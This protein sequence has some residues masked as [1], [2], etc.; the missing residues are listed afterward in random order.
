MSETT[1]RKWIVS[2]WVSSCVGATLL[3]MH[4]PMLL[5]G[6]KLMQSDPCD[7]RCCN[8]ILEHSYLWLNGAPFHNHF[9][10]SPFYYPHPNV[11]AYTC[12]L[13]GLGPLYWPWRMAGLAPDTAFQLWTL[14][15]AVANVLA[16]YFF[17]RGIFR[18]GSFPAGFAAVFFASA[19]TLGS[20][21]ALGHQQ[22][23]CQ[24]YVIGMF[25]TAMDMFRPPEPGNRRNPKLKKWLNPALFVACLVLQLYTEFY[26]AFFAL[27]ALGVALACS[28][29]WR[30]RRLWV[31]DV[32]R[33]HV[34]PLALSGGL[35][36]LVMIP[37]LTHYLAAMHEVGG[38][39]WDEV[40]SMIPRLQS[41]INMGPL[42]WVYGWTAKRMAV[43]DLPM[44]S[45]H[46]LGLGLV[47]TLAC[48]TGLWLQ[49]RSSVVRTMVVTTVLLFLLVTQF[50]PF[51]PVAWKLVY[52]IVPGA[53]AIRG[54][55]RIGML[56]AVPA[57]VGLG[58]LLEH[59]LGR[60]RAVFYG[61][62]AVIG[63]ACLAEQFAWKRS[64]DKARMREEVARIAGE[65]RPDCEAFFYTEKRREVIWWRPNVDAM[66]AS[67]V[68]GKPT[69]NGCS[70][71]A[72]PQWK[73]IYPVTY[74]A[75]CQRKNDQYLRQWLEKNHL[76][77]RRIQ[78]I[79]Q[80]DTPAPVVLFPDQEMKVNDTPGVN[81]LGDGW[82]IPELQ[83][84]WSD[85][86]ESDLTFEISPAT[87]VEGPYRLVLKF[88]TYAPRPK[89]FR[90]SLLLN[91][92]NVCDYRTPG[93]QIQTISVEVQA[94]Q[95][96]PHNLL[97]FQ[98]SSPHSPR[99]VGQS[100]DDR[101]LCIHLC[102]VKLESIGHRR[103]TTTQAVRE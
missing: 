18:I 62:A 12:L 23:Y 75:Y 95:L 94:A 15:V 5:S 72:P 86:T 37:W 64:Y 31:V 77:A 47:T 33:A 22:L 78:W 96:K 17:L 35:A 84:V 40:K 61:L 82:S 41:W 76:D 66:W 63:M 65:V 73:L 26:G 85:G 98:F 7:S 20:H 52:W 74:H 91:G 13:A 101:L 60:K 2:V 14:T 100:A 43:N 25:A 3:L 68:A 11:T 34:L 21:L 45:E 30:E 81:M 59:L 67:L 9:W 46:W 50:A 97:R 6:L 71:N 32:L 55:T 92:E 83:G 89:E 19:N 28:L 90:F 38:R 53:G 44:M 48:G 42:S 93:D 80:V 102:S 24:A 87:L 99:D 16:M 56:L 27:L 29:V 88:Y 54:V 70:A 51:L 10:D 1:K 57:A 69:V 103:L 8:Y 4:Y 58:F 79:G 39:G 36:A 49:R